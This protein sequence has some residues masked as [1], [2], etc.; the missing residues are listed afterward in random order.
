MSI[1]RKDSSV[2]TILEQFTAYLFSSWLYLSL[3]G[4]MVVPGYLGETLQPLTMGAAPLLLSPDPVPLEPARQ[5]WEPMAGPATSS[6]IPQFPF[7]PHPPWVSG[8]ALCC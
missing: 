7:P 2:S 4:R 5:V 6:L 8:Y 1:C 3:Q